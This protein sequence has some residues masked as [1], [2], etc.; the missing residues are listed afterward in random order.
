MGSPMSG[1]LCEL[2]L[3]NLEKQ[4]VNSFKKDIVFYK[5]YVDDVCTIWRNNER[6][7]EFIQVINNNNNDGLK[8]KL[9]QKSHERIHFLDIDI[10]LKGDCITM[11]I[12]IKPTHNPLYIPANSNDPHE[13]KMSAFR[14]LIR[15]AF[16]YCSNVLDRI[17]EIDRIKEVASN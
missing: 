3:H 7:H 6:I 1:L 11:S 8:L 5:R 13:Y 9:E 17:K 12:Y 10:Q 16:T 2:V 4:V 15:T 14:A